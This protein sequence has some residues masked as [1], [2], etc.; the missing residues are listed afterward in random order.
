MT[1][2]GIEKRKDGQ[3]Y[4]LVFDPS[5]QDSRAILQLVDKTFRQKPSVA[6]EILQPY[7]RGAKH[8]RRYGEFE[9]L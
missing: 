4:L 1:I 9:L 7:R 8:L 2:V 5:A 3:L 6:D